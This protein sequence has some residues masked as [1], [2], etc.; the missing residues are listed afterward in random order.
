VPAHEE[1]NSNF[2]SQYESGVINLLN[3]SDMLYQNLVEEES[4]ILT[5]YGPDESVTSIVSTWLAKIYYGLFY[6]DFLRSR[7]Q[8]WKEV[9]G[10]VIDCD[11]FNLIRKSYK[12]G[13]G[14]FLPSS[15]FSFQVSEDINFDLRTSVFSQVILVKIKNIILVL[16]IGDGYLVKN[17]LKG[18]T[19]DALRE[20]LNRVADKQKGFPTQ[21]YA[22]AEILALWL[23]IPKAPSIIYGPE[24]ITN[25]SLMT[26]AANPQ[27]AYAVDEE[28]L[29]KYRNR[30][31][32]RLCAD[33]TTLYQT[34]TGFQPSI[35]RHFVAFHTIST[36]DPEEP[37]KTTL[38]FLS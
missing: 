10:G 31:L 20:F 35:G 23:C 33:K 12:N 11:N 19:L 30:R 18:G 26:L 9:S 8:A 21:I 25:M 27:V 38:D 14:F 15:L 16:C 24:S 5:T 13:Y 34:I 37:N 17:Y 6:Y 22:W 29:R 3:S 1:C 36:T 28:K 7:N 32:S 2:G 4:R